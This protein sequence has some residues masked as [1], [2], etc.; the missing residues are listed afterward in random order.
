MLS[1][2]PRSLPKRNIHLVRLRTV[3]SAIVSL[4]FRR[5]LRI[6]AFFLCS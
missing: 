2:M 1:I 5:I 3:T 4:L 6:F